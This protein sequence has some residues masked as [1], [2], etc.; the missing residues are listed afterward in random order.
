MNVRVASR[1]TVLP[2]GGGPSGNSPVLVRKGTGVGY[3][4]YHMHRMESIYG[5]DAHEFRPERWE[6]TNLEKK[7][8]WGFLPFHGGPR[9]CLGSA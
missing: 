4:V 1:T 6:D 3:S 8:G 2:A 9:I 7:A 5:A